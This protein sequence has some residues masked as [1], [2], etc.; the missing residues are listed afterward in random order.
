MKKT[1]TNDYLAEINM[2]P[3]VDI[4]LVLLVIFMVTAPMIEPSWDV[5]LP[6]TRN[7]TSAP[8]PKKFEVCII[9][10]DGR[11]SFRDKAFG[12]LD[13]FDTYLGSTQLSAE[14]PVFIKADDNSRYGLVSQVL[15]VLSLHGYQ[16]VSLVTKHAVK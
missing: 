4:V 5:K 9:T 10:K 16:Q 11:I 3:F 8:P 12:R 13:E 6:T 7:Q 14:L 15:S 1:D 2:T